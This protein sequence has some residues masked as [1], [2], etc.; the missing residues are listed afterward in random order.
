MVECAVDQGYLAVGC[1]GMKH[2][3]PSVF[4]MFLAYSGCE[5]KNAAKIANK[6]WGLDTVPENTRL[7]IAKAGYELGNAN[8]AARKALQTVMSAK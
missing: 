3:G 1:D 6:I 4:A 8:P 5:A 2:R 7:G